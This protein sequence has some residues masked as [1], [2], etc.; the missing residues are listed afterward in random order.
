[1]RGEPRGRDVGIDEREE[2][3]DKMRMRGKFVENLAGEDLYAAT[4]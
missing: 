4:A 2:W 3:D 1:V